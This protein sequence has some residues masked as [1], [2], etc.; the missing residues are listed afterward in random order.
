MFSMRCISAI[1]VS[2]M[3]VIAPALCVAADAVDSIIALLDARDS[4]ITS[5]QYTMTQV[6][7][8]TA[9]GTKLLAE[10][11]PGKVEKLD[12]PEAPARQDFTRMRQG[13]K[14]RLEN[15]QYEDDLK[16][17]A[18]HVLRTWDGSIGRQYIPEL[19]SG[20]VQR[21]RFSVSEETLDRARFEY[22]G[23]SLAAWLRDA[24]DTATVT[25]TGNLVEVTFSMMPARCIL[26]KTKGYAVTQYDI[27]K[28]GEVA[29][30][31]SI[32]EFEH[33]V[34]TGVDVFIPRKYESTMFYPRV[35][36]REAAPKPEMVPLVKAQVTVTSVTLN[37]PIAE[38][39]FVIKFPANTRIYDEFLGQF[40]PTQA[41]TPS[42]VEASIR[43]QA[44]AWRPQ[45]VQDEAPSQGDGGASPVVS[46]AAKAVRGKP[47][48]T[49]AI[50]SAAIIVCCVG[51]IIFVIY[52]CCCRRK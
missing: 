17:I 31:M 45:L 4:A 19:R 27:L 3:A 16:T 28:G 38:D 39:Q 20:R 7:H 15:I 2:C 9:E 32:G 47:S 46:T 44:E 35:N 6:K 11:H 49:I 24:K 51:V 48:F 10:L 34:A 14:D 5:I 30:T 12:D 52:R 26:D 8:R 37:A 23:K 13:E 22:N 42:D 1:L 21:Q 40:I 41:L 18:G 33:C 36:S 50:G 25:S 29:Y 43:A